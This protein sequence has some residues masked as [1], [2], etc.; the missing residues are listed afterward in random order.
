MCTTAGLSLMCE[1]SRVWAWL[2][3][4]V[5]AVLFFV[6]TA[7]SDP[8]TL[9]RIGSRA[10]TAQ[11]AAQNI[12]VFPTGEGLPAGRGTPREGRWV[13]E[14]NCAACHGPQGEG[15]ADFPHLV[16]GIGTL[17]GDRPVFTVGSY[18]PY[19]TTVWDYIRRAMPYDRPGA[20]RTDEVYAITAY[21]LFLNG[22]AGQDAELNERTLARIAMPNREGFDSDPRPDVKPTR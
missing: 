13:Y 18:W 21:L 10:K 2:S 19:A 12:T 7:K 5:I 6:P 8:Q 1:M 4:T 22:I 9:Y 15:R 11:V 14:A 17:S 16:G 20:L 3:V